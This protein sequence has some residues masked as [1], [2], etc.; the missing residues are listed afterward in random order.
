ME[1]V[2]EAK[3]LI[4]KQ[5][6]DNCKNGVMEYNSNMANMC[7]IGYPHKCNKCG[8]ARSYPVRYPYH[9]LV[10]IEMFRE[11]SVKEI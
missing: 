10:P 4:V 6:C 11:P 8:H 3:I 1:M 2:A 7:H 9:K 5:F